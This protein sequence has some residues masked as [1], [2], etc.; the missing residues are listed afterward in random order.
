MTVQV[1]QPFE[2]VFTS[3]GGYPLDTTFYQTV[4]GMVAAGILVADDG[5]VIIASR[6]AEGIGSDEYRNMMFKYADDY[7]GFLRDI[8]ASD[9]VVKDQWEFQMHTRVLEKTGWDGLIAVNDAIDIDELRKCSVIPAQDIVGP[10]N[11]NEMVKRL[12]KMFASHP[13]RVA[14]LPRGPYILPKVATI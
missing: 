9:E 2:I 8:F 13:A 1:D 3:G 11:A 7:K 4:K 14:I 12:V 6:C 5:K 10:A